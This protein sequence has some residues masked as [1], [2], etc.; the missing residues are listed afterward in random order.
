MP[1]VQAARHWRTLEA[2][3]RAELER[4]QRE[5]AELTAQRDRLLQGQL[6]VLPAGDQAF[7]IA[8][9]PAAHAALRRMLWAREAARRSISRRA[10]LMAEV[11]NRHDEQLRRFGRAGMVT[12]NVCGLRGCGQTWPLF[13]TTSSAGCVDVVTLTE[14]HLNVVGCEAFAAVHATTYPDEGVRVY[15][16]HC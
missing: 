14:T 8:C 16:G 4:L 1:S 15:F 3:R 12:Y 7:T 6:T 2:R 10:Y 9:R 13:A 11:R 5:V